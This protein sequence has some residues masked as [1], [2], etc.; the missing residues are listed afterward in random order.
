MELSA[1]ILTIVALIIIPNPGS[2]LNPIQKDALL[3]EFGRQPAMRSNG[4]QGEEMRLPRNLIP[5]IYSIRFLPFIELDNFT[6]QG[7]IDVWVDC[8]EDTQNI[9]MDS[10]DIDIDRLSISVNK[11]EKI[12]LTFLEL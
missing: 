2:S 12:A 9:T 7:N 8:M 10:A 6:T 3:R 11:K 1:F 5:T 4:R